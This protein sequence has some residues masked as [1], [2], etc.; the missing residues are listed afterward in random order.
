MN[1]YRSNDKSATCGRKQRKSVTF[2][3]KLDVMKRYERNEHTVD[4]ANAMGILESTLRT[5][6]KQAEKITESCK[7]SM[8]LLASKVTQIGMP[9]MEKLEKM[10]AQWIEHRHYAIPV[11]T[12]I[13]QA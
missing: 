1:K 6:R 5:I 7:S 9:I 11:S 13:I 12:M 4:V 3:E 2:E 10:L 8:R